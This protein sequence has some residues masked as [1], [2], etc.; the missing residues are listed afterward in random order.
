MEQKLSEVHSVRKLCKDGSGLY[1]PMSVLAY[2]YGW[3]YSSLGVFVNSPGKGDT[4]ILDMRIMLELIGPIRVGSGGGDGGSI[5]VC[6]WN[7]IIFRKY[8]LDMY[9]FFFSI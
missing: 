5:R 3:T 4:P 9:T 6:V 1:T 2:S 8:L 7:F